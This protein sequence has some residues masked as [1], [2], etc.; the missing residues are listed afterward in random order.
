VI[1]GGSPST[2]TASVHRFDPVSNAWTAQ[3]PLPRKRCCIADAAEAVD[4]LIYVFG[5]EQQGSVFLD[6]VD[7]FDPVAGTWQSR[8]YLNKPRAALAV[9]GYLGV[10]VV[11]GGHVGN[12]I[13]SQVLRAVQLY[14]P[15]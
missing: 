5:G 8:P 2:A 7:A 6:D 13:P 14:D 11:S 9:S 3:T 4:G 1:G 10:L 12:T 15:R